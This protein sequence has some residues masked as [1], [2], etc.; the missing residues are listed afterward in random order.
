MLPAIDAEYLQTR[1]LVHEV[2]VEGGVT[3]VLLPNWPLPSG[4]TLSQATLLIRLSAGY[5]DVQP[6]MWWFTPPVVRADGRS[7]PAT[8]AT[9][10]HFGQPWQRWSRH[11]TAGQWRTGIDGLESYLALVRKELDRGCLEPAV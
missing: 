2:R 3:S 10:H 4:C 7:I 5:P 6:D 11:L 8:E 9:E 1:G